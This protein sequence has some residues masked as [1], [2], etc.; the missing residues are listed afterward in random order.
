MREIL[1]DWMQDVCLKYKLRSHTFFLAVNLIDRYLS[2]H[3]TTK[4]KL[5]LLGVTSLFIAAKYEEIYPPTIK[6]F[7][8]V[9][10]HAFMKTEMIN[11][12]SKILAVID[13]RLA[14][15]SI[16]A[17]AQR[18]SMLADFSKKEYYFCM[19][20]SELS[21]TSSSFNKYLPSTIASSAVYLTG[22][23]FK[24][25]E[26]ANNLASETGLDLDAVR[27]CAKD[28]FL[29]LYKSEENRLNAVRRKFASSEF[30]EVSKFK[31]EFKPI[32]S[33]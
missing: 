13:F 29:L 22:K 5:Q 23:V 28:L 31:L 14:A 3:Q 2:V 1:V 33:R 30:Y 12:E 32:S 25:V 11:L 8:S 20:V 19:F 16:L 15:P 10:D 7:L 9:C 21:L 18:Y 27:K 6:E 4:D 26:W 24:K 17:F